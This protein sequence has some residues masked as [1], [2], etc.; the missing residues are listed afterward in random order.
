MCC[1]SNC[2]HGWF[3][4]LP[5]PSIRV[6]TVRFGSKYRLSVHN[7]GGSGSQRFRFTAGSGSFRFTP[8]FSHFL[9]PPLF[10]GFWRILNMGSE[11]SKQFFWKFL[12][13]CS[14]GKSWFLNDFSWF[15]NDLLSIFSKASKPPGLEVSGL[16]ASSCLGG[17][18]EAKSISQ[19]VKL[20]TSSLPVTFFVKFPKS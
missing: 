17:N 20:S 9:C 16:E 15:S 8:I 14:T 19:K 12:N 2:F 10:W 1:F 3:D 13:E 6:A 4:D 7:R 11:K 5:W 18:R